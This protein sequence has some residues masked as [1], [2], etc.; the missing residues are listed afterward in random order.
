[1]KYKLIITLTFFTVALVFWSCKKNTYFVTER[2]SNE[3]SAQVKIGYFSA[4]TV[5]P[6]TILYINDQP[7][8]NTLT[9]P[10]PFPGGGFNTNGLSN[11]D[12]LWV[13][14]GATKVQGYTPVPATGNLMTKLFEFN[15][16]FSA[17]Q[18]YTF[19]VTDTGAN[20]KG[21]SV[22]DDKT[23]PDS[24]F[25]RIKFVHAM[26][27][28]PALDIYKGA[29]NTTATLIKGNI[30]YRGYSTSFDAALPTDSFFVRPAGAAATTNPIARR[31]FAASLT[32][33]RIYTLVAR[34]YS[35]A[36]AT[37]LLPHLSIVINQ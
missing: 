14:P 8:S 35:G 33:R 5:L 23:A 7:V 2:V 32:N 4:Y 10:F 15:E 25:A 20:T 6:N 1:M 27:N 37:N 9:A 28:V 30:P 12:Y 29:N 21:F 11:G 34:G 13:T 19:Y 18:F 26:P 31:A 22:P 24:G 3:G 36:T 17:N 16:T